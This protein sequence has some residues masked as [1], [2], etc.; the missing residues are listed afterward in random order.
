MS[1]P[2]ETVVH[3]CFAVVAATGDHFPDVVVRVEHVAGGSNCCI[4]SKFGTA[5]AILR[6][7][8]RRRRRYVLRRRDCGRNRCR[9][10]RLHGYNRSRPS[11]RCSKCSSTQTRRRL[12]G[13]ETRWDRNMQPARHM[14]TLKSYTIII[15]TANIGRKIVEGHTNMAFD[16]HL[17]RLIGNGFTGTEPV[18]N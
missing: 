5:C 9:F 12:I 7:V 11:T 8:D 1:V 17:L 15:I 4:G 18:L 13:H 6:V 3:C 16:N 14:S 10:D 2:I